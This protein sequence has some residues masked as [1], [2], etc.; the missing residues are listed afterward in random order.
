MKQMNKAFRFAS[1]GRAA[2]RQWRRTT[3]NLRPLAQAEAAASQPGVFR[4]PIPSQAGNLKEPAG[5]LLGY[6]TRE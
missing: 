4:I 3:S 1:D 5:C 6:G 2:V